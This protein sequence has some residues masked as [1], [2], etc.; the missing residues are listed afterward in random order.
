MLLHVLLLL[1]LL[2]HVAIEFEFA[3]VSGIK[4]PINQWTILG[5]A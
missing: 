1:L 2:L 3:A 4:I 5:G